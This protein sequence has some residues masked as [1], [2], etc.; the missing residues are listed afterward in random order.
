[1]HSVIIGGYSFVLSKY[2]ICYD[3][4]CPSVLLSVTLVSHSYKVQD[5]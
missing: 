1:M 4:V 3:K 5:I 2:N